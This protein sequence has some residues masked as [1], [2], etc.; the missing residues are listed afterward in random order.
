MEKWDLM[1]LFQKW[2]IQENDGGGWIQ[3]WY[4]VRAFVNV[5]I[6]PQYNNNIT[7][8]FLKKKH[9]KLYYEEAYIP[10]N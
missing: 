9:E 4:I 6:Y 10:R 3:L 7:K 1:N 8:I 5:T 2:R